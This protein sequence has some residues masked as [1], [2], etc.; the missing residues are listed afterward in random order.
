MINNY[1]CFEAGP[2]K[3]HWSSV[4]VIAEQQ[5][6]YVK[7]SIEWFLLWSHSAT[8]CL[9][10][11][12]FCGHCLVDFFSCYWWRIFVVYLWFTCLIFPPHVRSPLSDCQD[13]L[14][15]KY[16]QLI[17]VWQMTIC[18][19]LRQLAWCW[20]QLREFAWLQVSKCAILAVRVRLSIF[21]GADQSILQ[22]VSGA[23]HAAAPWAAHPAQQ[24]YVALWQ[25]PTLMYS[26]R[27][28][29]TAARSQMSERRVWSIL[30]RACF[31]FGVA[32]EEKRAGE[33]PDAQHFSNNE[34]GRIRVCA[35][36]ECHLSHLLYLCSQ[37]ERER[38]IIQTIGFND[39]AR[40]EDIFQFTDTR[41]GFF[42]SAHWW[43]TV[44]R[45]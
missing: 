37:R 20:R 4:F 35:F 44:E 18:S 7:P 31:G 23:R 36:Y 19:C 11:P 41:R 21:I 40:H 43:R 2:R 15:W 30:F 28:P 13:L 29:A 33:E 25:R 14:W 27:Q 8:I 16:E 9:R 5:R 6:L 38:E 45:A 34:R 17:T 26:T 24:G 42:R 1:S 10:H 12:V 3:G 32:N 22:Y 39:D